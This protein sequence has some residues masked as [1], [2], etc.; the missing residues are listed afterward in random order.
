LLLQVWDH[1]RQEV[2]A[3][4]LPRLIFAGKWGW[5]VDDIRLQV[6]RNWRLRSHLRILDQV[7]DA[8]LIWLYRHARFTVFPSLAEGYGLGV[9]E[10]LSFG[11]PVVTADCPALVEASEALMPAYAP[12]DFT[13]WHAELLRLIT[14]DAY[15][16]ELRGAAA[17]YSGPTYQEFGIALR[18]AAARCSS[19]RSRA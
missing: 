8:E 6:E 16:E 19:A 11:T 17:R 18:E 1:L 12:Y 10:S 5:G 14:D 7:S 15:L 2:S 4:C 9:A 3:D 13:G